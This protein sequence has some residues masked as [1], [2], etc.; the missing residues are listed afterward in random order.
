MQEANLWR[1]LKSKDVV[2]LVG[3]GASNLMSLETVR[4]SI[5]IVCEHM[6]GG[7]LRAA[8]EQQMMSKSKQIYGY[9]EVFGCAAHHSDNCSERYR[10]SFIQS[11]VRLSQSVYFVK[12][13]T[14]STVG[15]KL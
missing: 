15:S 4:S 8:V 2:K 7:T 11:C 1:K 5:F 6:D 3:I 10:Y 9:K 13:N 14:S 12:N